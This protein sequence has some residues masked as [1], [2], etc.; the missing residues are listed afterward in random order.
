MHA[1]HAVA[2]RERLV[3]RGRHDDREERLA[4][5]RLP[6]VVAQRRVEQ[7]LVRDAPDVLEAH[8]LGDLLAIAHFEAVVAE[9]VVHVVEVAVAAVQKARVIALLRA[10]PLPQ[11]A[12]PSLPGRRSTDTLGIG[13]SDVAIASSPRTVRVP[14]AYMCRN[15]TPC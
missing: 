13:G 3:I 4:A 7:I 9:E 1:G 8:R 10:S 5:S 6:V 2:E 12:M 14:D 15:H 11:L